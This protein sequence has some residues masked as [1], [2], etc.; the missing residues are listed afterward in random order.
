MMIYSVKITDIYSVWYLPHPQSPSDDNLLNNNLTI[1]G[2]VE[3]R[4]EDFAPIFLITLFITVSLGLAVYAI[5]WM[6]W[7]MDPGRDSI[8]YR[9]VSDPTEGMR[10]Q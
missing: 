2:V 1:S 6:M 10:M 7:T 8:I 4:T 5:S 9:Q 3:S